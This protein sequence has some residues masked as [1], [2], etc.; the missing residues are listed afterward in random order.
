MAADPKL[1]AER[2]IALRL[3]ERRG[4]P[5]SREAKM[6]AE[7]G[8]RLRRPYMGVMAGPAR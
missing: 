2:E 6:R 5:I 7:R 3:D 4:L 1:E 8:E